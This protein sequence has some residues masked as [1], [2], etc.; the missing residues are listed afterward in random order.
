M[1]RGE[2][3]WA[4]LPEPAGSEPGF[5]RPVVV[6]QSNDFNESR[7]STVVV[8]AL[9]SNLRRAAAPGNVLIPR[10]ATGLSKDSVVN[11]SQ[12]YTVDRGSLT[13]FVSAVPAGV[14]RDVED[15]LRAVLGL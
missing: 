13:D 10:S 1:R 5:R 12:L 15:G 11:V 2:I 4:S 8:A 6:V 14:M 3:W 7:I 9:T